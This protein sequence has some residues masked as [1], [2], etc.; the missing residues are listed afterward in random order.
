M[1]FGALHSKLVGTG[2][3]SAVQ[4]HVI[5]WSR[6]ALS[7]FIL[8]LWGATAKQ[9]GTKGSLVLSSSIIQII[10]KSLFQGF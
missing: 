10:L 1:S 9:K 2:S 5:A 3:P 7:Q 6:T 4:L 8:T